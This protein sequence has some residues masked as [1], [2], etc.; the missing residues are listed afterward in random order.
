MGFHIREVLDDHLRTAVR[1]GIVAGD[2]GLLE[3]DCR[4]IDDY[5]RDLL[6]EYLLAAMGASWWERA[7]AMTA[8]ARHLG[9]RRTGKNIVAALKSAINA[10]LRRG[11]L[12]RDGPNYIRKVR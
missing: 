6:V 5:S 1:R 12:E 9:F 4:A 3:F 10:A 8:T 11:L 2:R 7:D